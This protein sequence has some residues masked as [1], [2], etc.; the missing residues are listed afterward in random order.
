MTL[1]RTSLYEEHVLLNAKMA[2]FADF[3]MPLQYT[4]VKDEVLAVRKKT[5]IFDVSHMGEFLIEGSEAIKFVDYLMTNDFA[6]AGESKAVYSPLCRENGTIVDDHIAYKIKD[7]QVLLCVNAANIQKD[8]EWI[9]SKIQE[10]N[11]TIIDKSDTFSL[12]AVQGPQTEN[13]CKDLG[14]IKHDEEFPYFSVKE[15][16]FDSDNIIISRTG[17]TGED[18][19]EI[20]CSHK[21]AKTLWHKFIDLGATPCGLVARDILRLEVCFPLYGNELT[22]EL[23]PLD[24]ALKWTVKFKKEKFIGKNALTSYS[25]RYRLIKLSLDKGVPR[26][27]YSVT[28]SAGETIGKVTSG[29]MSVILGKGIAEALIEKDKYPNDK[30]FFINIRNKNY[31][32]EF[33]KKP[34]IT[35]GHK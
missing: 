21:N 27:G 19:F 12:L 24:T 34:F 25:P 1:K 10:F 4:S 16:K 7:N 32:A 26:S 23:T 6:N 2:P 8:W 9:S 28:N 3:S 33:H 14:L 22:D 30:E 31:K 15:K 29:T 11:C 5:G 35:G 17:Y 13:I 20:F 18:G